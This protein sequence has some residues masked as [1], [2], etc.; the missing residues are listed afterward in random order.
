MGG[1]PHAEFV[2]SDGNSHHSPVTR[3]GSFRRVSM[4][5]AAGALIPPVLVSLPANAAPATT[6]IDTPGT[7]TCTVSA[8]TTSLSFVA[9]GGGGGAGDSPVTAG[10][11]GAE[12]IGTL[13]VSGGDV[14]TL[15]VASGGASILS[16]GG[17]GGGGGATTIAN[18]STVVV[19]AGGGG[20]GAGGVP[21]YSG[22]AA[23]TSAGGGVTPAGG[24][25]GVGGV[26]TGGPSTRGLNWSAGGAGGA[27]GTFGQGGGAAGGTGGASGGAGANLNPN[28][29]GGGGGGYGGG[30]AGSSGGGAAG[31]SLG[32]AGTTFIAGSNGGTTGAGGSGAVI[33]G[34]ECV[35]PATSSSPSLSSSEAAFHYFTPDGIECTA[36]SP[37]IVRVGSLTA[38]PGAD[39]PCRSMPG[40]VITGWFI[41]T[42]ADSVMFGSRANPFPPG[43]VVA[44]IESQTFT[45]ILDE[46][47]LT[48][49]YDANV[50]MN[51]ACAS[52]PVADANIEAR[53]A[54]VWVPRADVALARFPLAAACTPTNHVLS[55]WTYRHTDTVFSPGSAIPGEW[56]DASANRR[57]LYAVWAPSPMR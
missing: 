17:G 51:D 8:G 44:V 34:S 23:G 39:A 3:F 54:H 33:I 38:L 21:G 11:A 36:I 13:S 2:R 37:A 5:L 25:N 12:V 45:A 50:A 10:G 20:G 41:A 15:R 19:I 14:L 31:G 43:Q 7:Y 32:P 16:G 46:P 52:N 42:A 9:L 35:F 55:G 56:S 6:T 1:N 4:T 27:G 53:T 48:F 57:T 18:G 49:L 40:S 29:G 22:A 26:G 28:G 30:G 47:I 24:A